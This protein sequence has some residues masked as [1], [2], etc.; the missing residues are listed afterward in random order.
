MG[1]EFLNQKK[2][3]IAIAIFKFNVSAYP[4]SSNVYD[5]LGEAYMNNGDKQLAILNYKKSLE[6]NTD[7]NNAKEALKKLNEVK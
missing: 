5:S 2:N 6:L 1:Y 3:L 7:N 4:K